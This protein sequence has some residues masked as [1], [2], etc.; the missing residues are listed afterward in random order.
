MTATEYIRTVLSA[1][2]MSRGELARRAGIDRSNVVAV[3]NGRRTMTP[4]Y[5]RLMIQAL[6]LDL[7]EAEVNALLFPAETDKSPATGLEVA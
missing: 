6:G 2:A 7:S 5:F 4:Y 3:L 1:R